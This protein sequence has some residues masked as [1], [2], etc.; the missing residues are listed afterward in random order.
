M[1]SAIPGLQGILNSIVVLDLTKSDI[2]PYVNTLNLKPHL[3]HYS[4]CTVRR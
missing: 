4:R 2:H 1:I 3:M